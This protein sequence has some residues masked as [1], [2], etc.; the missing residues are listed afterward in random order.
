MVEDREKEE[1]KVCEMKYF[2]SFLI[3]YLTLK[4]LSGQIMGG[5]KS[6]QTLKTSNFRDG[7]NLRS[8]LIFT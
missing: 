2:L 7:S 1:E 3:W 5:D 6:G 4:Q 8:N